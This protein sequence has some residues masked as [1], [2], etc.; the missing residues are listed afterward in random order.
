MPLAVWDLTSRVSS[1]SN[2]MVSGLTVLDL[3]GYVLFQGMAGVLYTVPCL[4]P[5]GF[6]ALHQ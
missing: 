2:G 5:L 6:V 3:G 4:P 1:L